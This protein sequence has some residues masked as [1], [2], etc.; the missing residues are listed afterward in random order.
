MVIN[1]DART[2]GFDD[3]VMMLPLKDRQGQHIS[4]K[5]FLFLMFCLPKIQGSNELEIEKQA[6]EALEWYRAN[7]GDA[8]IDLHCKGGEIDHTF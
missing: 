8:E 3:R 2:M 1:F 6:W 7:G 4:Q 5:E